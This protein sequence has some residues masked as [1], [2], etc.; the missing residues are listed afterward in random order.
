MAS[1]HGSRPLHQVSLQCDHAV[2]AHER[3]GG[4][5][6]VHN[7]SIP[8]DIPEGGKE[9]RI[10]VHQVEGI[11]HHSRMLGPGGEAAPLQLV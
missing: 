4:G 9:L 2:A 3:P 5:E 6:A 11:V 1:G 10:I 8:E 7:Q